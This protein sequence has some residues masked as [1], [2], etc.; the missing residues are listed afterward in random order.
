MLTEG[1]DPRRLSRT[2]DRAHRSGRLCTLGRVP[3]ASG[4]ACY[5]CDLS[6]ISASLDGAVLLV[7]IGRLR[8]VLLT[9]A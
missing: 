6:V 1:S 7:P 4:S 8:C 3:W 2:I 9:C 5:A